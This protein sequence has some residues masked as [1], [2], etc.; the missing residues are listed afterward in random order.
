MIAVSLI[1]MYLAIVRKY[2]RCSSCH[3]FGMMLANIP[4]AGL[5]S[6]RGGLVYISTGA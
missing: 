1:L 2:D 3:A 5:A 4:F 6:R